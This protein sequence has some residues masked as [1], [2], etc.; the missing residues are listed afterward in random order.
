MTDFNLKLNIIELLD[1][2]KNNTNKAYVNFLTTTHKIN[3]NAALS[4]L[5]INSP[6]TPNPNPIFATSFY[7][8]D[9]EKIN[10]MTIFGMPNF[11]M[12]KGEEYTLIFNNYTGYSFNLH[13]HGLNTYGDSDGASCLNQFGINTKIGGTIE[14]K[15]PKIENNSGLLWVHA[16]PMFDA[17]DYL[18]DG[19]AGN[20]EIVDD[21]SKPVN[22]LFNYGDNLIPLKYNCIDI[23]EDG[24]L[25]NANLYTDTWRG[26]FGLINGQSCINWS[27][28]DTTYTNG[29]YHNTTKNVVK[30]TILNATD[31]FRALHVGVCDKNNNIKKFWYIIF[32]DGFTNPIYTDVINITPSNRIGILIDLNDFEDNESY[33]FYYNFD[34]TEVLNMALDNNNNLIGDIPD[35]TQSINPSPSPTPIPGIDPP[36]DDST[37][38]SIK[39]PVI[40]K[41]PYITANVPN[42]NQSF[43]ST[44]TIKKYLKIK[45]T[46]ND[47]N[48]NILD[49]IDNI[50]HI[51]FGDNYKDPCIK[52]LVKKPNFEY[53][54]ANECNKNY[55]SLLNPNYYYNL[56]NINNVPSRNFAFF[57]DSTFNYIGPNRNITP[58]YNNENDNNLIYNSL[59][60]KSSYSF[61]YVAQGS[62]EVA[63]STNRIFVD[64]WNTH[65]LDQGDAIKKYFNSYY[66][67]NYFSYKPDK[68][69]TVLFKIY[70]TGYDSNNY[71]NY[72]MI[73][74][75]IMTIDIFDSSA[76]ITGIDTSSDPPLLSK[77]IKFDEIDTPVNIE[78]W[79][80]F[81]NNKLSQEKVV[82]PHCCCNPCNCGIDC[83][84]ESNVLSDILEYDWTYYPYALTAYNLQ[85]NPP[86]KQQ[87]LN[88]VMIRLINK[89]K[90][91]IRISGKWELLN[92]FG[93]PLQ[94]MSGMSGMNM[95][96]PPLHPTGLPPSTTNKMNKMMNK[97]NKTNKTNKM[98]NKMYNKHSMDNMDETD[99]T[100]N[101]DNMSKPCNFDTYVMDMATLYSD[102]T[103]PYNANDSDN[104]GQLLM[105]M[106][107]YCY[108]TINPYD[109]NN[110]DRENNGVYKGFVD[111]YMNDAFQNFSVK[112]NSSEKWNYY[113][114]DAQDTHPFHFHLT[115]GYIDYMNSINNISLNPKYYYNNINYSC[116]VFPIGSQRD[117]SFYLKFSNYSSNKGLMYNGKIINLGFMYHCHYSLH[118][119]MNMM[120]Q[121]YVYENE[122]ENI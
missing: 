79:T 32:D 100:D 75:D 62:T 3:S 49:I 4:G 86:P 70:P 40:P 61:N 112:L 76:T 121:Y 54:Y 103:N 109:K 88:S 64:Q 72:D 34:L 89:S 94:A 29:L 97:T 27:T 77:T 59:S 36:P 122:F 67:N 104:T 18:Y 99:P 115:S 98:M 12:K 53:Y 20:L 105:A 25:N 5:N 87:F 65:E 101:M 17:S 90:Y 73:A 24:S 82:L 33:L 91:Q 116:D 56:P 118:H 96:E 2:T 14:I 102:P 46:G 81:V 41:V 23:N 1:L 68:L 85:L 52:E 63:I 9:N 84:C 35:T 107:Q 28:E 80:I 74:N 31:S 7:L 47:N 44:Y 69:P 51:V 48:M 113:N 120:G 30:I 11:R 95:P 93:K 66:Y 19:I 71:V 78:K 114:W 111:G 55:I 83:C 106:D 37:Q 39:Y 10:K 16:H 45:Y 21:I 6:D 108:L 58:Y 26:T 110:K 15:F 92:L 117:I 50:R 8:D 38:T 22:D 42:G 119:D 57:P 60:D 13:W 43:P